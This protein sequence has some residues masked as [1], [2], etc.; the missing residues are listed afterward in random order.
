MRALARFMPKS[1]CLKTHAWQGAIECYIVCR[2]APCRKSLIEGMPD[3]GAI[4][5]SDG[6]RRKD[7][8]L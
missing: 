4:Q 6:S 5:L 7:A 2:H 8:G 3:C 1:R